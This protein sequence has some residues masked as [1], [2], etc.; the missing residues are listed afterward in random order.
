MKAFKFYLRRSASQYY[1]VQGGA[2]LSGATA[3][4]LDKAPEEWADIQE[5]FERNSEKHGIFTDY[6]TSYTFTKDAARM[7]RKIYYTEGIRGICQLE[8]KRLNHFTQEYDPYF[9]GDLDFET[10]DDQNYNF[11][12]E[13][14]ETGLSAK[15]R[16]YINTVY[17]LPI[18]DTDPDL[19]KVKLPSLLAEG[20]AS[21]VTT[22]PPTERLPGFPQAHKPTWVDSIDYPLVSMVATESTF[23]VGAG[24]TVPAIFGDQGVNLTDRPWIL[25]SNV[26]LYNVAFRGTFTFRTDN[27]LSGST[28]AF[29]VFF[30]VSN[31]VT[32]TGYRIFDGT[33]PPFTVSS[34]NVD[35]SADSPISTLGNTWAQ[36]RAHLA[37]NS[38]ITM[39]VSTSVGGVSS[40]R[41]VAWDAGKQMQLT[42]QNYTPQPPLKG[43]RY[44]VVLDRLVEKI[45]NGAYL[46][47]S[48]LLNNPAASYVTGLDNR[49]YDSI[50][51]PG[52][53]IR[54]IADP[55]LKVSLADLYKDAD[56]CWSVGM[57]TRNNTVSIEQRAT[58]YDSTIT[59]IDLG[60]AARVGISSA[61]DLVYSDIK[62]GYPERDYDKANGRDEYNT[63]H[64]YKMPGALQ[65]RTLEL[66]SP[67]RRDMWGMFFTYTD[68]VL[69]SSKDSSSDA[70]VFV[71]EIGTTLDAD[72]YFAPLQLAESAP[73]TGINDPANS[74][75]FGF[76][77]KHDFLRHGADLRI[78]LYGQDGEMITFQTA[79]KNQ[80]LVT[81]F[82]TSGTIAENASV[83][84]S[85]LA[86]PLAFPFYFDV[87]I[88]TSQDLATLI[89]AGPYGRFTTTCQ[90]IT[91][92]GYLIRGN[93]K[94]ASR[95]KFTFR[96][97][98]ST[99]NDTSK[100]I[101]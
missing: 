31:G 18:L 59:P 89:K 53:S 100:F 96:L 41:D 43:L 84:V 97:L 46:A 56:T 86:A 54:G 93:V 62:I 70:S 10:A 17:E 44:G 14:M 33:V 16:A 6:T 5:G 2:V 91:Y 88:Q 83:L 63:Y 34:F 40:A 69:S 90:G 79:Y 48:T 3:I 12:I 81:H 87:D 61:S 32:I 82:N 38:A 74:F 24:N 8:I 20:S 65:G 35:L 27:S 39:V 101:R 45:T 52:D 25:N 78:G 85:S 67:W 15:L 21:W 28:V 36:A 75:N 19:I 26:D 95:D 4:E 37:A 99:D 80:D 72:G 58:Y 55:V 73:K 71:V 30:Q 77:P 64:V 9:I 76:T 23:V 13:V 98:A 11:S 1:S 68:Y 94:G 29:R 22:F 51:F 66:I 7:L 50:V 57:D 42:F 92:I 49:P 60:E 47:S